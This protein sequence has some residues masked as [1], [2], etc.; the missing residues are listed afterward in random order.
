MEDVWVPLQL[1]LKKVDAELLFTN[2]GSLNY[3]IKSEEAY[4]DFF[5]W[6]DL[7]DFSNYSKSSKSFNKTNKKVTGKM[8]DKFGWVIVNEFAG[9]K[10]KI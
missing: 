10:S 6:K 7:F 9:L 5:M 1:Y 4:E 8:R 3:E 2:T